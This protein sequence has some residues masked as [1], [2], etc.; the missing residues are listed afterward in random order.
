MGAALFGY[1]KLFGQVPAGQAEYLRVPHAQF[2]PVVV[3]EGPPDE[4]FVTCPT[5]SP[6]RGRPWSTGTCRPAAAWRCWASARSATWRRASRCTAG[7][8]RS[9]GSTWSGA[10]GAAGARGVETLDLRGRRRP[11][12]GRARH[13]RRARPGRGDRRRRDGSARRAGGHA[14]PVDDGPAAGRRRRQADGEG[15]PRPAP[16]PLRSSCGW[17]RPTSSAGRPRS[18]RCSSTGTPSGRRGSR[19]H[20]V[21]LRPA[22]DAYAAFQAKDDGAVKILFEPGR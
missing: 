21:P 7:R 4:R 8:A 13:D 5:S 6:P 14:R 1:T 20:R 9:S 15:R 12:R 22:P 17:G 2:G 16:L 11:G 18:C 19:P 3:P 10:A